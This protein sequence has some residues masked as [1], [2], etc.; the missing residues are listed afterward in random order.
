MIKFLQINKVFLI[1]MLLA[2]L[3]TLFIK[4]I[5][6]QNI[7]SRYKECMSKCNPYYGSKESIQI[8]DYII[9]GK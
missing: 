4:F 5:L 7:E 6:T 9:Y 1:S 8:K 3:Y 2:F